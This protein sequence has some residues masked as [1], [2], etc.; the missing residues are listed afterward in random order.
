MHLSHIVRYP[1]KSLSMEDLS[2]C[3]L[4]PGQGLPYDRH[5]ALARPDGDGVN[6]PDWL[7]KSHFLVLARE[8]AMAQVK[9]RFDEATGRF[10]FE[11]PDGLH[12]EGKLSTTEGRAAIAGAMAKHLG[13]DESGVPTLVEAQDIGYFDTTKGPISILNMESVR[14]LE[15][16]LSRKLDPVRFRMNLM[17]EGCEAWSETL[18]PG[19]QLKIGE[20]ILQI[21]EN[22]GRCKATHVNPDT[23]ELDI[24]VLHALKEHYGHT[25]MGVYAVVLE[26]GTIKAG[27]FISL[28]D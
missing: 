23:G 15:K 11:A 3:R 4:R 16:L 10:C 17:V 7:P 18:W 12:A 28:L 8:H 5:W 6:T 24:K 27:D 25:Q 9:S 22:T 26:G 19:K 2:S 21:T 13:L 1:V 20:S 14:A